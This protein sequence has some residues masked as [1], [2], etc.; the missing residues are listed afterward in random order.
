MR[1]QDFRRWLDSQGITTSTALQGA[2]SVS[3]G[4]ADT[5][6][7]A[8]KSGDDVPVKTTV[9]LAM[10]AIYHNLEPWGDPQ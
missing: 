6:M 10:R 9:A 5:W 8:A 1:N 3:K 4:T 2:L 7:Q